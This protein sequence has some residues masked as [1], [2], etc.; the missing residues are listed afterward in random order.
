[1]LIRSHK[2]PIPKKMPRNIKNIP[3]SCPLIYDAAVNLSSVITENT[4]INMIDDEIAYIALYFGN[5]KYFK[6]QFLFLKHQSP[7]LNILQTH[8][9]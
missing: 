6:H 3:T 1:M 4:N 8:E 2:P 7:Y 5:D 9:A